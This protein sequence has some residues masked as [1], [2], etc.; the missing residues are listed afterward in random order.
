MRWPV[1][2]I[3]PAVL[4]AA[5]GPSAPSARTLTA[6]QALMQNPEALEA[7][8][9]PV[10]SELFREVARISQIEA[11]REASEPVLFPV[12]RDGRFVAAPA[13]EE[14]ADLLQAPDAGDPYLLTFDLR[15]PW[16]MD[17]R[18]SLQGLSE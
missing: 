15:D 17:R 18:E 9:T 11:G 7:E 14:S 1:L 12:I 6:R 4:L 10:R 5:C 13:L 16:G 8:V 2:A 3:L